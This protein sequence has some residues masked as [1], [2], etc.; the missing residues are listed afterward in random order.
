MGNP[1]RKCNNGKRQNGGSSKSSSGKSKTGGRTTNRKGPNL[2]A[3]DEESY[4]D[5]RDREE[6]THDSDD[7]TTEVA[8][9]R[10]KVKELEAQKK[11]DQALILSNASRKSDVANDLIVSMKDFLKEVAW[12][13]GVHFILNDEQSK[14]VV[15][16][17]CKDRRG[18]SFQ[19]DSAQA[20]A[21][22][23][24]FYIE[25]GH[26]IN[27]LMN[28]HR[29]YVS[30]QIKKAV[31]KK[32]DAGETLPTV[33]QLEC[34]LDRTLDLS[35]PE[36][37]EVAKFYVGTLLTKATGT[38]E[39]WNDKQKYFYRISQPVLP[40]PPGSG[41]LVPVLAPYIEAVGVVL[42]ENNLARWTA[43]KKWEIDNKPKK[44]LL[45]SKAKVSDLAAK[46]AKCDKDVQCVWEEG[47]FVPK[48]TRPE[49]GQQKYAGWSN[50]GIVKYQEWIKLCTQARAKDTTEAWEQ[51]VLDQLR[52]DKNI[53]DEYFVYAHKRRRTN[54]GNTVDD[55]AA[56][57]Q[58]VEFAC[59]L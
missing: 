52:A 26:K 13:K 14:S 54:T 47:D 10:A 56:K 41:E 28:S 8:G 2:H 23:T 1:K 44:L 48:H 35:K 33:A 21:K 42:Y 27:T 32:L 30:S 45:V 4:G 18:D 57:N 9:L 5:P 20:T 40:G 59:E 16:A 3:S 31:D 50:K 15:M 24:Q 49:A 22:R 7:D 55:D 53:T 58:M 34:C 12:N 46:Q 36:N 19:G 37:M 17:Y 29:S 11:A 51:Q 43:T 39:V 38:K 6:Y 25:H